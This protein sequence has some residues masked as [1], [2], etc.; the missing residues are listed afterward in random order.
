[1][2]VIFKEEFHVMM[3]LADGLI[4]TREV[5]WLFYT[6]CLLIFVKYVLVF[7][8]MGFAPVIHAGGGG[9]GG[10]CVSFTGCS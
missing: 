2:F 10:V 7:R 3:L 9:E 6:F 8:W 5:P 1:M 4:S